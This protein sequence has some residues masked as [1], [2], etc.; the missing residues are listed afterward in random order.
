VRHDRRVVGKAVGKGFVRGG[1]EQRLPAA[2]RE[3]HDA[4]RERLGEALCLDRLGAA[5][6][7]VGGVLAQG[8]RADVNAHA[9][10]QPER[11]A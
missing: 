5:G 3:R 7:L 11:L 9:G 2:S 10:A 1:A 6:H 4:S 8:D